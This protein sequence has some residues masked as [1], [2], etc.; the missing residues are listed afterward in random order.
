MNDIV[1]LP[2]EPG[3]N[4]AI[5]VQAPQNEKTPD[6]TLRAIPLHLSHYTDIFIHLYTDAYSPPHLVQCLICVSDPAAP[7]LAP[8]PM[9][10]QVQL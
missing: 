8:H 10:C 4:P 6:D 1:H 9:P 2:T 5:A 3:K 7:Q